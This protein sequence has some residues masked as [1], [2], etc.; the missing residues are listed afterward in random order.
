MTIG[1]NLNSETPAPTS[2]APK[3]AQDSLKTLLQVTG[4]TTLTGGGCLLLSQTLIQPQ[5]EIDLSKNNEIH[6]SN[7]PAGRPFC[8]RPLPNFPN[9]SNKPPAPDNGDRGFKSIE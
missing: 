6:A 9:P 8:D 7:N 3:L 4:V 5:A 2:P 1:L